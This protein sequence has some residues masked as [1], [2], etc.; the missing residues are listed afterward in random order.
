MLVLD[1][2]SSDGTSEIVEK[3]SKRDPHV[4]L[5]H[6]TEPPADWVGKNF[7]CYTLAKAAQHPLLVSLDADVR[8][9]RA[10]S[11]GRLAKFITDS[12]VGFASGVPREIAASWLE[13]LIIPLIH[14]VLLGFLP[15]RRMRR[16]NEI[17]CAAARGQIVAVRRNICESADIVQ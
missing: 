15:L 6:G 8:V 10:D 11:L 9:A 16:T 2:Q 17:N 5:I 3:F 1:D 4:W 12:R 7:A 14:F 13:R